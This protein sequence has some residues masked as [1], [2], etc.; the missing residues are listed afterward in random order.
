MRKLLTVGCVL[1]GWLTV[2]VLWS[3]PRGRSAAAP[4]GE[5]AAQPLDSETTVVRLLLGVGD[6]ETRSWQGRVTLDKGEVVGLEP[7]RFRAA[8]VTGPGAWESRSLYLLKTAQA[9][10]KYAAKKALAKKNMAKHRRR[11]RFRPRI[12]TAARHRLGRRSFPPAFSCVSRPPPMR[13]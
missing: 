4:A 9:K 11:P 1:I 10:A 7:W 5:D 13:P 8:R 6:T 3:T 12:H 2:A